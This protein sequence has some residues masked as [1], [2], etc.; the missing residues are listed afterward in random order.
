MKTASFPSLRVDPQ[1]RQETE[2]VLLEGET[3]SQ[4]MENAVRSQVAL[5]KANAEFLARGLAARDNA[6]QTGRYVDAD[7]VLGK[8]QARLQSAKD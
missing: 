3:L 2:S 6:R 1:L 5:R 8:L 7:T 4:F